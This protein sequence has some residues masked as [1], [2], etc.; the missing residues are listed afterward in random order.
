M[1]WLTVALLL[2]SGRGA[3]P[4]DVRCADVVKHCQKTCEKM[5][6][7]AE[8][9]RCRTSCTASGPGCKEQCKA[10]AEEDKGK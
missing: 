10:N 7:K 2:A 6:A 5:Y 9:D 3:D 8:A 4:C 1:T